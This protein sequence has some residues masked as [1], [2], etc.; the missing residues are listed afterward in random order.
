MAL[1]SHLL[2]VMELSI[3]WLATSGRWGHIQA[4][5]TGLYPGL[6]RSY[7]R[8]HLCELKDV[9]IFLKVQPKMGSRAY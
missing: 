8:L 6:C 3:K 2:I 5:P 4:E 7:L 1:S 9:F